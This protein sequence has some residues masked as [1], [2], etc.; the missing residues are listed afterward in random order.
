MENQKLLSEM[1]KIVCK[2]RPDKSVCVNRYLHIHEIGHVVHDH[3]ILDELT[4]AKALK[5]DPTMDL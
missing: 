5:P 4:N 1:V 2:W 3:W